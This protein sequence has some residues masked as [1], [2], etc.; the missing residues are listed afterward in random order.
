MS[1][2]ARIPFLM[3]ARRKMCLVT[4]SKQKPKPSGFG[5]KVFIP[6]PSGMLEASMILNC[7]YRVGK[8]N[9][10][11]GRIWEPGTVYPF[12]FHIFLRK[13]DAVKNA[14][15]FRES[16][17]KVEYRQAHTLGEGD[18]ESF[19]G[20]QVVAKRMKILPTRKESGAK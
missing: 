5:W 8:W 6:L 9:A 13:K 7:R 18:L 15:W 17:R 2:I 20:P 14:E 16:C 11:N 12:G 3:R 1:G 4:V 10:A 19:S